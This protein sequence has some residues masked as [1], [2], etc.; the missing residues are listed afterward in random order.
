MM[1]SLNAIHGPHGG[2]F[3]GQSP[4]FKHLFGEDAGA[5]PWKFP[6]GE[7]ITAKF[8]GEGAQLLQTDTP[9]V[10]IKPIVDH[11]QLRTARDFLRGKIKKQL[12]KADAY[13]QETLSKALALTLLMEDKDAFLKA[14]R[15]SPQWFRDAMTVKEAAQVFV[16]SPDLHRSF[17]VQFPKLGWDFLTTNPINAKQ[18]GLNVQG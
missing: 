14:V 7:A 11:Q 6:Q 12:T 2:R 5:A 13:N 1:M 3:R 18:Y 10:A 15:K 8:Y 4:L 9:Y 16:F 17:G